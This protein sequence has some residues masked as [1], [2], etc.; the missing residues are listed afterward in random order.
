MLKP[1][2]LAL[3]AFANLT[4]AEVKLGKPLTLKNAT[5]IAALVSEPGQYAGKTVQARG[6][7]AEVCQM[8]GCWMNLVD[9]NG[10][11]V[12]IKVDDGV[13][14]FPKDAAGKTAIAEGK[15][16]KLELTKEQA[17]AKARHEAGENGKRFD[18]AAIA[19]PVTIYQ[20]EGQGAVILP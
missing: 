14:A 8:M 20:I 13:I 19:G 9:E 7:V 3:L 17:M 5:P 6:K 16:T 12:R 18:A 15:F 4:A 11:M 2:I 10:K 1:V